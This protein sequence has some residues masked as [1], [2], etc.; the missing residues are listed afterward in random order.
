[1]KLKLLVII[2][3]TTVL[4][5]ACGPSATPSEP[6]PDVA[7]VRTSAASTVVSQFTLTAAAFTATTAPITDTPAP[8]VTATQ[9]SLPVA[10][11]TNAEGTT[12]ALC[13]KYSWDPETVDVNV[14]DNTVVSPGQEFIKTWK[15]KNIGTCTWGEGYELVFSYSS[16]PNDDALNGVAQ[17]LAAAI[18]PQQEVEV[19]VQ[20]TAPDLPGT[21]FSVWTMRN[22]KDISFLGNDNKALYVQVL[23]Q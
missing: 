23:V 20:F 15:I 5:A 3:I 22:A 18:A 14:P 21:Y 2:I 16:L 10:A 13:D 9:T 1:M 4:I 6:T 19:S 8:D 11:V 12:V 17:P 7:A